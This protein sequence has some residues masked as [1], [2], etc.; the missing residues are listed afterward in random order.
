MNSH[1]AKAGPAGSGSVKA[2]RAPGPTTMLYGAWSCG[3]PVTTLALTS[4]LHE[5]G[6]LGGGGHVLRGDICVGLS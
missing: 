3:S 2:R 4:L 1:A 5:F 6:H